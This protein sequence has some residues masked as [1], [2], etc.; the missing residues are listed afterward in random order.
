MS[1]AAGKGWLAGFLFVGF[2]VFPTC[3]SAMAA[4]SE[5]RQE[6]QAMESKA[7]EA[8][9]VL[10]E[11]Y[12][13]KDLAGFVGRVGDESYFNHA[14]FQ[15]AVSDR[16]RDFGQMDLQWNTERTLVENDKVSFELRWQKRMVRQSDGQVVKSEGTAN[17]VFRVREQV[18][19][20]DIQGD[21]PF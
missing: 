3:A 20:L 7:R 13:R 18:E 21:S 12:L 19:L 8:L 14:D 16:F 2:V 11:T 10:R 4:P 1:R 17:L 6:R 5:A 15:S 9:Q